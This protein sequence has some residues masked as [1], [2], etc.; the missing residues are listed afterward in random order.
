MTIIVNESKLRSAVTSGTCLHN[1]AQTGW[2]SG[3]QSF[4]IPRLPRQPVPESNVGTVVQAC[5][6]EALYHS[7]EMRAYKINNELAQKRQV[8]IMKPS[9]CIQSYQDLHQGF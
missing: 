4:I 7:M 3:V 2:Q 8:M 6:N 1:H 9:E 5:I